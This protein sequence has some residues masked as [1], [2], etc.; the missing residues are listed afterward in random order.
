MTNFPEFVN[1]NPPLGDPQTPAPYSFVGVDI[2]AYP[3]AAD[4]GK[5]EDVCEYFLNDVA[6]EA[7][8]NV[9]W[10]PLTGL[11]NLK[12]LEYREMRSVA[13]G[14]ANAGY[15]SQKEVVFEIIVVDSV[16]RI[17]SFV[18]Y[19]VVD[20]D[21]SLIAGREVLGYPKVFGEI[22]IDQGRPIQVRASALE[23]A[24]RNSKQEQRL[25]LEIQDPM[26]A[27]FQ[28]ID[29]TGE[30]R[31][32]WPFGPLEQLYGKS[33]LFPVSTARMSVLRR[34]AGFALPAITL[35]QFRD[36][37]NFR[38]ACYQGLVDFKLV[39]EEY[40]NGGVHP[41]SRIEI[42][43]YVCSPIRARLGLETARDGSIESVLTWTYSADFVLKDM[44]NLFERCG[45][46]TAAPQYPQIPTSCRDALE[47]SRTAAASLVNCYADLLRLWCG[48]WLGCVRTLADCVCSP[49]QASAPPPTGDSY[50]SWPPHEDPRAA[51]WQEAPRDY[52][53][54][55]RG[56]PG[57]YR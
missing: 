52:Y 42:H 35:K 23:Q 28:V 16:G 15:G 33:G 3:L 36:A 14:Y 55:G 4:Y 21:W 26:M 44:R 40:R 6:R 41:P 43:D 5:L 17:S 18:P 53:R 39:L 22:V 57:T 51:G 8:Y 31:L 47:D 2:R 25:L 37:A 48:G 11:V 12:V 9:S 13:D 34:L 49:R 50:S 32:H 45:G 29:D 20:N 24:G 19:L 7:G 46:R 38:M 30:A 56:R 10:Q 54:G 27:A 1:Q